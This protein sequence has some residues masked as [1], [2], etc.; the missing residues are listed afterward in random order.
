[1]VFL[2]QKAIF[3]NILLCFILNIANA[4][5]TRHYKFQVSFILHP[6]TISKNKY[7]TFL[8]IIISQIVL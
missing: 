7:T 4:G 3:V 6:F 1:M 5:I 2:S 8:L